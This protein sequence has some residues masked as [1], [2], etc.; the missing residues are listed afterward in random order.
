[1]F[2]PTGVLFPLY[3]FVSSSLLHLVFCVCP[4]LEAKLLYRSAW[5]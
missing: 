1:M 4:F 3:V 5:T 2:N